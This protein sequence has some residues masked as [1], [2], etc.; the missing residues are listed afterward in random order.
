MADCV[1]H[2]L[3][4]LFFFIIK[5][6]WSHCI[7]KGLHVQ[8][9]YEFKILIMAHSSLIIQ[10]AMGDY[11]K[12]INDFNIF[13]PV[14]TEGKVGEYWYHEDSQAFF[15][16]AEHYKMIRAMCR[17]SCSVCDKAE[18]QAGQA[19]Q[20]RRKSKFR[21]I[22]QLKGHLFHQHRL[23]MCS[24]CLEGRK[25]TFLTTMCSFLLK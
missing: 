8:S 7:A 18:D 13:P 14:A 24:L 22:E 20:V 15:D 6:D 5:L 10:Q 3:L 11:T 2:W 17:L 25:V 23:Y 1:T 19:A 12:V 21:S 9:S 16:D 4:S